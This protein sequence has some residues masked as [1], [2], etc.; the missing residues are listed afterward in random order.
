MRALELQRPLLRATNNG[1]TAIVDEF[2]QFIEKAPQF[3]AATVSAELYP[4]NGDTWYK[5]F[6]LWGAFIL[7]LLGL[8][9][10]GLTKARNKRSQA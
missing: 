5:Q 2:G 3:K 10:A 7:A 4:V 8:L 9:P 6:G 1:V